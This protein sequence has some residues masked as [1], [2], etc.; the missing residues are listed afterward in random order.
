MWLFYLFFHIHRFL[1]FSFLL[2]LRVADNL[3]K[4]IRDHWLFVSIGVLNKDSVNNVKMCQNKVDC[5]NTLSV[6]EIV[7]D[8]VGHSNFHKFPML[9]YIFRFTRI[10]VNISQLDKLANIEAKIFDLNNHI[11]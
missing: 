9:K 4:D 7:Q 10:I 2:S 1:K 5:H 11:H 6:N 8:Q 3:S